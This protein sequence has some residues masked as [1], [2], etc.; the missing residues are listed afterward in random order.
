MNPLRTL[1]GRLVAAMLAILLLALAMSVMLGARETPVGKPGAVGSG[2]APPVLPELLDRE[3]YQD[4]LVLACF[5]VPAL[6]LIWLVS[7]WSLRPL[8]RA[9]EEARAVRPG[10]PAAR[11]SHNGL[12][13]E[14]VPL[15]EAVNGALDRMAEAFAAERR[16]TENAAHELR[17]PL[18]VLGL[19][20]QRARHAAAP[21]DWEAIERDMAQLNRL[22]A[23]LLDLARRENASRADGATV[24]PA[25]NLSRIAR[26][27]LAMIVPIAEGQGRAVEIDVPETLMVCG[28]AHDL[29]EAL[30][31]LLE[32]AA[33]HGRG[34]IGLRAC[35]GAEA[36]VIVSDEGPGVPPGTEASVFERFNKGSRSEGTGLGL[37]IVREVI[38]SHGGQVA[39]VSGAPCR[40]EVKLPLS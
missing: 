35:A 31:N 26:E 40:V 22:V 2:S 15:V 32:N 7:S 6:L 36:H 11:I 30:C 20:L 27:A 1:R 38:R 25:V 24:L 4:G 33:L 13:A 8:V 29:R 9:S 37:S 23:Q 39:F 28:D 21:P 17:T 16:F 14:I 34:T 18:A 12:P 19:R 10:A 3:P 5:C